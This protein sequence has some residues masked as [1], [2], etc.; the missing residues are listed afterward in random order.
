MADVDRLAP[1]SAPEADVSETATGAGPHE[2]PAEPRCQALAADVITLER[3]ESEGVAAVAA[4]PPASGSGTAAADEG[5][6]SFPEGEGGG[7]AAAPSE[8]VQGADDGAGRSPGE[9]AAR[10]TTEDLCFPKTSSA[11]EIRAT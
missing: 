10:T 9:I 3:D 5:S 7:L 2:A 6:A 1:I 4:P 8:A 11:A